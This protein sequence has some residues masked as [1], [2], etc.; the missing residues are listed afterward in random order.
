MFY[1]VSSILTRSYTLLVDYW[2]D[3]VHSEAF[4]KECNA[5]SKRRLSSSSSSDSSER[6]RL[7]EDDDSSSMTS[8]E[9]PYEVPKLIFFRTSMDVF[10]PFTGPEYDPRIIMWP[11][12]PRSCIMQLLGVHDHNKLGQ[13]NLWATICEK[14]R[15]LLEA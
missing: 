4:D 1:W 11:W 10:T 14:V 13:E 9:S 7:W 12:A 3:Y 8:M 2:Y 15:D 6:I 5:Q